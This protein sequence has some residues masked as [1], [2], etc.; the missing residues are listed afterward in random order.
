MTDVSVT[1]QGSIILFH[2]LTDAARTWVDEHVSDDAQFFGNGLVVEPR[3]AQDLADGM[4]GD[5]LE[6]G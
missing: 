4:A 1:N 2:L 5:G 3:Y 6:I